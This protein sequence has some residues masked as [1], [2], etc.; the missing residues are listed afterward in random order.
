M[1]LTDRQ[2][3][4]ATGQEKPYKLSDGGGL[5]LLVSPAGGKAWRLKYRYA[6]KEKLLS[7]GQYPIVSLVMARLRREQAKQQLVENIDPAAK[8]QTEKRARRAASELTFKKVALEWHEAQKHEWTKAYAQQVLNRLEADVFPEIGERAIGLLEPKEML[9]VLK[10]VE[11]RGVLETNRRLKQYCSA[12]FRFG[13]ASDYCKHD[14]VAPLKG[15]LKAPPRAKH[16]KALLRGQVGDF[17][18]RLAG[19][20]GEAE[21]R[22]GINLAMLMVPRT[23][24]LRAALWTEFENLESSKREGLW[25]IPEERMKMREVHLVPLSRQA[26]SLLLEL[27]KLTGRSQYLFPSNTREGFMSNNTMLYA[28]YRMG[29]HGR[30]T[31]HGFRRLFS[32]EANEHGWNNDWVERQLAHDERDAVRGAYNAAQ[33]L[34]QRREM[35]QWWGD[36]LDMLKAEEVAKRARQAHGVTSTAEQRQL[37]AAE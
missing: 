23:T 34:P 10:K 18:I 24:E 20:D 7:I 29:L 35:L 32:T 12:I 13:I 19:Y 15:A 33:Y 9:A 37:C 6:G 5:H 3:R 21:T 30:T 2:I 1:P 31:T 26:T 14:P 27:K 8:K 25:R 11:A 16:H 28:I 36:E 22:I 4:A 17:L